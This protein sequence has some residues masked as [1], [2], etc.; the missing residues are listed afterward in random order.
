VSTRAGEQEVRDLAWKLG[1]RLYSGERLWGALPGGGPAYCL[2]DD[3]RHNGDECAMAQHVIPGC[4][5][6]SLDKIS[7]VLANIVEFAAHRQQARP[8]SAELEA[9][10]HRDKR[11]WNLP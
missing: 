6:V 1:F 2:M 9:A 11:K 5:R 3:S 10:A 8:G 4:W 7:D